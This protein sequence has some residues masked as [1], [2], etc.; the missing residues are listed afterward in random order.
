ML[1]HPPE[2]IKVPT[3]ALKW[4]KT[5]PKRPKI[6]RSGEN[7]PTMPKMV[8]VALKQF[9]GTKHMI[10]CLNG[11]PMGPFRDPRGPLNGPKQHK[12]GQNQQKWRKRPKNGSG[13]PKTVF[14][15]IIHD[16]M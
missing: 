5:T 9:S 8:L 16:F 1:A 15:D 6:T 2:A 10:I 4:P 12:N 3:G 11:P 7:G 14:K 13:G